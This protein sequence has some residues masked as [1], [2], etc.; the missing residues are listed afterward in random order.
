MGLRIQPSGAYAA[1]LL[2]LSEQVPA[3]VVFLTDGSAKKIKIG[4]TDVTFKKTTPKNMQLAGTTAGLVIQAFK[5][6][7]KDHIT[8]QIA[9]RLLARLNDSD[10]QLLLSNLSASPMWIAKLIKSV[11]GE[12]S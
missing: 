1:N 4:N 5:Y 10:R 11:A 6:M 7:G 8:P 2:G 12:G 9:A 3:K